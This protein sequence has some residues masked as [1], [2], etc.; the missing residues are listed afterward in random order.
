MVG[1]A[2]EVQGSMQRKDSR[3]APSLYCMHQQPSFLLVGGWLSGLKENS[4][5]VARRGLEMAGRWLA[6]Q[7]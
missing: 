3:R 2:Q 4:L 7:V 6:G 1:V 5:V